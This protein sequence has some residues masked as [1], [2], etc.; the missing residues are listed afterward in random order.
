MPPIDTRLLPADHP[1][2]ATRRLKPA[3]ATSPGGACSPT[4][5]FVATPRM[6]PAFERL[7][8]PAIRRD[9][10]AD[11]APGWTAA[12]TAIAAGIL[13]ALAI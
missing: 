9:R 4:G 3:G 5:G 11:A 13:L 12:L 7:N 1:L 2:F 10:M 8:R 6:A